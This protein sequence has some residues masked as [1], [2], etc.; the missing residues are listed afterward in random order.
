VEVQQTFYNPP[1][2]DTALRWRKEAPPDFEFTVKAWQLITHPPSSPTYRRLGWEVPQSE[3]EQYGLFRPTTE[4]L[5]AWE[6]TKEVALALQ[7]QVVVFQT[8][9]SFT[10]CKENIENMCRFF[11]RLG[12][13]NFLFAWE[14]RGNW[15]NESVTLLCSELGL[16]HCVD[17]LE[18]VPLYGDWRYFRLHGGPTY[19]HKYTDEELHRLSTLV[20]RDSYILFNNINMYE[21]ALKFK[22]LLEL[23]DGC[24]A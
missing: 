1:S 12:P 9:A 6:R 10:D 2:V 5:K 21:D 20:D 7:A 3:R 11:K 13:E 14:P 16:V 8:P 18:K 24:S 4:V 22:R 23:S 19:R 17:P 15:S